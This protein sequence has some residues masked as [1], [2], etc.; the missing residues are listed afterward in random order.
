M[1]VKS[2]RNDIARGARRDASLVLPCPP[3]DSEP[4]MIMTDIVRIA[5]SEL[6]RSSGEA[7]LPDAYRSI[8][9]ALVRA[10]GSS[11]CELSD[12][13]RLKAP[14]V[15]VTVRRMERDGLVRREMDEQDQRVTR[16]FLTE[17]GIEHEC[18]HRAFI[19]KID[20]LINE[21]FS[22]Q[23]RETLMTLLLFTRKTLCEG[24]G[25]AEIPPCGG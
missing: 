23:D 5:R 24:L 11:Q 3:R 10:D 15:S 6:R 22:A 17:K 1:R 8:L 19:G 4:L 25:L 9:R 20:R 18:A 13:T 14:T 2:S 16:V 12:A 21:S 7:S